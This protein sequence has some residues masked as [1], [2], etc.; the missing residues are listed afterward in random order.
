MWVHKHFF[1]SK[2][3]LDI[4]KKEEGLEEEIK[5]ASINQTIDQMKRTSWLVQL[6]VEIWDSDLIVSLT[7]QKLNGIIVKRQVIMLG[8]A[9]VQ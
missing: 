8:I 6:A 2:I 7:N 4:P 3:I 9:K 5:V 1:Q